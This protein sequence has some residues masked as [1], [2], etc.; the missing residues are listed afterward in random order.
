VEGAGCGWSVDQEAVA[1]DH[2]FVLVEPEERPG[3][4]VGAYAVDGG[5]PGW[6][7]AYGERLSESYRDFIE[8]EADAEA[9]R[10]H[11]PVIIPGLLRTCSPPSPPAR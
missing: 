3:G 8:L 6:W 10:I 11:H 1:G 7:A 9:I 5:F 2:E 4:A